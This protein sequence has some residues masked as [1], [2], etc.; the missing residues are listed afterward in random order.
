[1]KIAAI[2]IIRLV[3]ILRK[4]WLAVGGELSFDIMGLV[5]KK[6]FLFSFL[7]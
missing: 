1:M 6:H 5:F 7:I 4:S 2:L 3:K